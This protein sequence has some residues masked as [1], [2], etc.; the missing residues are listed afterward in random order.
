MYDRHR[1]KIFLELTTV[2]CF[3]HKDYVKIVN[4][5]KSRNAL[6]NL[7]SSLSKKRGFSNINNTYYY[8]L[9]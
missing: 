8:T 3:N 2:S 9:K 5:T 7:K 4:T 6:E 1:N